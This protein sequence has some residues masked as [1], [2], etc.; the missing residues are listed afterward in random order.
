MQFTEFILGQ[1]HFFK[2]V[3]YIHERWSPPCQASS[4][5]WLSAKPL[6]RVWCAGP[7]PTG[8]AGK[9]AGFLAA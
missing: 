7:A 4:S 5:G 9:N 3:E 8:L 6:A 1:T 2:S